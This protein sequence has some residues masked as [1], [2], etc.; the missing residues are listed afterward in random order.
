MCSRS[1]DSFLRAKF[2]SFVC[3]TI[4]VNFHIEVNTV[5]KAHFGH[6][7]ITNLPLSPNVEYSFTQKI[8]AP[9]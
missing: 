4:Q 1:E 5:I 3:Q 7:D 6:N 9:D 8:S 2:S